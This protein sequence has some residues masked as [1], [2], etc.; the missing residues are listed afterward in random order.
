MHSSSIVHISQLCCH[1]TLGPRPQSHSPPQVIH[2][3]DPGNLFYIVKDGEAMVY[4]KAPEGRKEINRLFK[5][6][7]F[8][9]KA[10]LSDEARCVHRHT[11]CASSTQQTRA[12]DKANEIA[13]SMVWAC[14]KG[15]GKHVLGHGCTHELP[16]APPPASV[17]EQ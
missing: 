7:F 12:R 6:D 13:R 15:R 10:L 16:R 11:S 2:E 5:A 9:E 17:L 4:K 8:G 1:L 3:G 14:H